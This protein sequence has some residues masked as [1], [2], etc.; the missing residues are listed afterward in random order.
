MVEPAS[1]FSSAKSFHQAQNVLLEEA[2]KRGNTWAIVVPAVVNGSFALELYFKCL[3]A[4]DQGFHERSEHNFK[5][6]FAMFS[7]ETSTKVREAFDA[8][9]KSPLEEMAEQSPEFAKYD[10]SLEGVLDASQDA[11]VKLRYIFEGRFKHGEGFRASRLINALLTVI[12]QLK[13]EW[14]ASSIRTPK[15]PSTGL[16]F[17]VSN[18]PL[19]QDYKSIY[20]DGWQGYYGGPITKFNLTHIH[21]P[22]GSDQLPAPEIVAMIAMPT[23][24]L[25][26]LAMRV[27]S[28]MKEEEE[29]MRAFFTNVPA[30]SG[31][32]M[33]RSAQQPSPPTDQGE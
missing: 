16:T 20:A 27:L 29:A 2:F 9:R 15:T 7:A 4:I 26:H 25:R 30:F 32:V 13:P 10:H 22:R 12:E 31:D 23:D 6:L 14:F 24:M 17:D 11:F 8:A 19:A 28:G 21:P 5:K 33:F 1:I 3:I 18:I